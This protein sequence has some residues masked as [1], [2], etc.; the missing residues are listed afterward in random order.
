MSEDPLNLAQV[1][2]RRA[3]TE[4][5]RPALL[6]ASP[7]G[8]RTWT[9]GALDREVRRVAAGLRSEGLKPGG[10]VLIRLGGIDYVL[11][12]LGTIAAGGVAVPASLQLTDGEA[13]F[14]ARDASA[15]R[16]LADSAALDRLRAAEPGD[17]AAT[18]AEA[19]AF[20]VYTSGTTSRP[21]GVLHAQRSILGRRPMHQSWLGLGPNDVMLHAG[22]VNWTYTLGVGLLDP[23]CCGATAILWDGPREP[24]LWPALIE[25]LR[26]TIFAAVPGV[27]RQMLR[28]GA[29]ERHDLASLRHGVSAGEALPPGL[30]S[31]WQA[32]TGLPLYEAL[33]QSEIS[34]YI[35]SGPDVPTRPGSPGRP[36]PG[37]RVAILPVEGGD[38]PLPSGEVG[39]LAV[40]RDEPGLMLG[41]WE[42]PAEMAAA[43]R[44]DW[45]LG[46]DLAAIDD[47]GYLWHHG[48]ADEIMNA[49]GYRVS[50]AEVETALLD[51]PA[52][53]EVAVTEVPVR[54]GVSIIAAFVVVR[55]GQTVD[56]A[57]LAAHAANRLAAY[58]CPREI[59]IVEALPRTPNGKVTR[60]RLG[61]IF[62]QALLG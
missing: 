6:V 43:F 30:L 61:E 25:R 48:R 2:L 31:Q 23:W 28:T 36:Q 11:A 62:A 3:E 17:W 20:L 33:G 56:A 1:C 50:P 40:H 27:Y 26:V 45:F 29:L 39:L 41:Y 34:T 46:G 19:P 53:A 24:A 42:R 52:V 12:F 16:V 60:K 13:D 58:K 8:V 37:R 18:G 47:A 57:G 22:A 9:Y 4:P 5:D 35:S 44:G 32:A 54:E 59:R 15:D 14:L 38:E 51:H 55:P 7:T 21:K 10:R 49:G